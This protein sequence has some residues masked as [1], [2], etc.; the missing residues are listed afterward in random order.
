M[1][2]SYAYVLVVISG[3]LGRV[4]AAVQVGEGAPET[5]EWV[6]KINLECGSCEDANTQMKSM[7]S[8][9]AVQQAGDFSVMESPEMC[10][11]R[12][13]GTRSFAATVKGDDFPCVEAVDLD[14][15]HV[16]Y[17][18][19]TGFEDENITLN[20]ASG[21]EVY[22]SWGLDRIDQTSLPL[23][24]APYKTTYRGN[25]QTIYVIDTGI[26][27][28]HIE[29]G[30][31][32]VQGGNFVQEFPTTDNHGHGTHVA[33]TAAGSHVG[34]APGA[35]VVGVKVLSSRGTGRSNQVL[36]GIQW[37]VQ[38]A[39]RK[40]SVIN[41]SLGSG[42]SD[43]L[44]AAVRAA[45]DAG[46]IVVVAAGNANKDA[47]NYSPPRT[48][49][50]ARRDYSVVSV[51]SS[52]IGDEASGFSNQG[53]CV[54]IFA[55][56]SQ[57]NSADSKYMNGYRS[58]SGTSMASPHVAGLAATLLEKHKGNKRKAMDNLFSLAASGKL[59]KV[60]VG[61]TNL[62]L[63]T[64]RSISPPTPPT[65][66]PTPHP[67]NRAATLCQ[68]GN[69]GGEKC[70]RFASSQFGRTLDMLSL[71]EGPLVRAP[72]LMCGESIGG[73][74]RTIEG[75]VAMVQRGQCTFFEKVRNLE[76]LGARAVLIRANRLEQIFNP[77]FLG[78]GVTNMHSCMVPYATTEHWVEGKTVRWGSPDVDRAT[79]TTSFPTFAPSPAPVPTA[80]PTRL[81]T[82]SP[83]P[84]PTR[85]CESF[86]LRRKCQNRARRCV[87]AEKVCHTIDP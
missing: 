6:A 16:V 54:D 51:G 62:L 36:Q 10:F 69:P 38:H 34:V 84:R 85:S 18:G 78:A 83:T 87:W 27:P 66:K 40:A 3:F 73:R 17:G 25:G 74:N 68:T 5:L 52:T 41:L 43:T 67:T 28:K 76:K 1:V 8:S 15:E 63:Q 20:S 24:E 12:F 32:A 26:V 30:N 56:G 49:G 9:F 55:P 47:C 48:G 86:K 23:D 42:V 4:V 35:E 80:Y 60:N 82:F 75:S 81:P 59:R 44:D 45:S 39:G 22:Y 13:T 37:A 70:V 77:Q 53:A 11:L 61:T 31:R 46:H 21:D 19:Y 71:V 57:I 50:S 65:L 29:F 14:M 58:I 7:A 79:P 72:G 2:I 33:G 64:E